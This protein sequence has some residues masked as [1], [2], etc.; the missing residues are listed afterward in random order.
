MFVWYAYSLGIVGL[1]P[2]AD[3][4]CVCVCVHMYVHGYKYMNMCMYFVYV[5]VK[6]QQKH[7]VITARMFI[8]SC[9][10]TDTAVG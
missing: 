2:C 3:M 8:Y 6:A 9:A 1:Q 4:M 5:F 10:I 7:H